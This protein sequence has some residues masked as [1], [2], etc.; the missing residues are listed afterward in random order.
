MKFRSI[1]EFD[2]IDQT[3][4]TLIAEGIRGAVNDHTDLPEVSL[5][6]V[7]LPREERIARLL[8]KAGEAKRQRG[9]EIEAKVQVEDDAE[10]AEREERIARLLQKAAEAKSQR[11][12]EIEA[13]V[14]V[15]D[16]AE[17]AKREERI[18]RLLQ[19]AAEAKRQRGE[20]IEA[21]VQ[22]EDDA[23]RAS[24]S[25][26]SGS[27]ASFRNSIRRV[28]AGRDPQHDEGRVHFWRRAYAATLDPEHIEA[29]WDYGQTMEPYG[30]WPVPVEWVQVGRE[31]WVTAPNSPRVDDGRRPWVHSYEFGLAHPDADKWEAIRTAF[32]RQAEEATEA[33]AR[34]IEETFQEQC[35]G[36]FSEVPANMQE[37]LLNSAE[38]C[39][40]IF[41]SKYEAVCA[42]FGWGQKEES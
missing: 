22:V 41:A 30:D 29:L 10:R 20:E 4:A 35:G 16:D 15:E 3:D 19:K 21:K 40:E 6:N 23:E 36:D 11:G 5:G 34:E 32:K 13:K 39:E 17:R 12:E 26:T 9:E 31:Y 37:D 2:A 14:E 25:T 8:Q 27:T 7:T 24:A 42:G 28:G 18:A 1:F 38:L 33:R